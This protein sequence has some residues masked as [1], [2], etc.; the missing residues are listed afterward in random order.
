MSCRNLLSTLLSTL[1]CM[2]ENKTVHIRILFSLASH[3]IFSSYQWSFYC[4]CDRCAACQSSACLL[5]LKFCIQI[6]NNGHFLIRSR[7]EKE[8]CTVSVLL[9][10]LLFSALKKKNL[11]W[12]TFHLSPTL[13]LFS[14][15]LLPQP[16]QGGEE[17]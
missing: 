13:I 5:L 7:I 14:F 4:I 12:L 11:N 10:S 8:D 2:L 9:F 17:G 6:W 16:N 1:L 3:L 15:I